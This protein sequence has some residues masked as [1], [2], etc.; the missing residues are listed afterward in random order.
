MSI[1]ENI[2][3]LQAERRF[4]FRPRT[5]VIAFSPHMESGRIVEGRYVDI[6][7]GCR[8]REKGY[9]Y[10]EKDRELVRARLEGWPFCRFV[11]RP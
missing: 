5:S 2:R 10:S 3:V 9:I 1:R 7:L 8:K 11:E 4:D 6:A